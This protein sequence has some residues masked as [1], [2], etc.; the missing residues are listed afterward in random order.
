MKPSFSSSDRRFPKTDYFFQSGMGEWRGYSSYDDDER[1]ELR[2]FYSLSREFMMVCARER[3]R[4]M[5]VFGLIV[6]AAA[7]PVVYMIVT[8]VKLL[9]KGRPL[10]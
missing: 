2:H 10:N 7:W 1:S 4:E 9:L 5:A 6:L 8:V 3:A